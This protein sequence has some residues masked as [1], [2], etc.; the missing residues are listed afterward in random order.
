MAI[1]KTPIVDGAGKIVDASLPARLEDAALNAAFANGAR[2]A[3]A[4]VAASTGIYDQRLNIYNFKP[5]QVFRLRAVLARAKAGATLASIGFVGDST[6]AGTNGGNTPGVTDWPTIFKNTL[7][8]AGYPSAGS[9]FVAAYR[10]AMTSDPRWTYGAGWVAPG[11][12]N[13]MANST[14][15]NPMTFTSTVAGTEV[16]VYRTRNGGHFTVSIDGGTPV[17]VNG[18]DVA[19]YSAYTVTGLPNTTHTVSIVRTGVNAEIAGVEILN[20]TTGVRY[21]NA[22]IAGS[23]VATL[24]DTDFRAV[25][26]LMAGTAPRLIASAIFIMCETNDVSGAGGAVT[27]VATYKSQMQTAINNL[28][29]VS[30]NLILVTAVPSD[31]LDFTL[32]TQALYELADTND[33]PLIDLQQRWVSFAEANGRSLMGD[34]THPAPAGNVDIGTSIVRA[35][36]LD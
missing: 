12:G 4:P 34:G 10:G 35:L 2:V 27:P 9:G 36:G 20:G 15:A 28:K 1:I 11:I 33:L 17:Q 29:A 19:A 32:Y 16:R 25:S 6:V 18:D 14:T 24:A 3:K 21:H 30:A 13:V 7:T 26:N 22:G 5:S 23:K 31:A 8:A